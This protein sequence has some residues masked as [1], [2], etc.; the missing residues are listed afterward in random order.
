MP[1]FII[2]SS[3]MVYYT[4]EVEADTEE[5]ALDLLYSG[6]VDLVPSDSSGFEIFSVSPL[7]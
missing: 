5:Q 3:E 2:E 1:K 7:D 6:F 4:N